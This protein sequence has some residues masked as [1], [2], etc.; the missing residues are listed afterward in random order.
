MNNRYVEHVVVIPEDDANRQIVVG[1]QLN[2]SVRDELIHVERPARGWKRVVETFIQVHQPAMK[3]FRKRYV[4]LMI[5]FDEDTDRAQKIRCQIDEELRDRVFILGTLSEPE[6][7]KR[8]VGRHYDDIGL[9]LAEDCR[10]AHSEDNI[11]SHE[12]LAQNGFEFGRARQALCD[13]LFR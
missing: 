8:S 1:F 3:R 13:F 11:W 12:L 6:Q 4:V 5:D 10:Q 7:L 2:P 9:W